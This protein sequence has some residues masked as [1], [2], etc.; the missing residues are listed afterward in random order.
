MRIGSQD[1][2]ISRLVADIEDSA[3]LGMDFLWDVDAKIDLVLQQLIINEEK[4]DCC[5][6]SSQQLSLRCITR[7]LVV[8]EPQCKAVVPSILSIVCESSNLVALFVLKRKACTSAEPSVCARG[9]P[10]S[11]ANFKH[12]G[13]STNHYHCSE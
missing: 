2:G 12:I 10:C 6:E 11:C 7:C 3:I 5:S 1:V 13:Q 8:I 4:I 9:W